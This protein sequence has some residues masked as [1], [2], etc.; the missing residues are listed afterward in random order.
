M[1]HPVHAKVLRKRR[2]AA[3]VVVLLVFLGIQ[4]F[5]AL[6]SD[7]LPAQT[8]V[9]SE[10]SGTSERALSVLERLEVKG[11]APKSG[12]KRS[13]F[14]D[15]WAS[16]AG[17]DMRNRMLARAMKEETI[18]DDGCVVLSGVLDDLYTAKT[19]QFV[20]GSSTSS[21]VQIDHVV[22]LSDAWQK[23]AQNLSYENRVTFANDPLNLL[24]VDGK[25][26]QDKGDSDAASWLPP[27]KEY[28]CQ[29]VARQVAVKAK[30]SLWVT[31]AEQSAIRRVLNSC[32]EQV[33]PIEKGDEQVS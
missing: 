17:C 30:Y 32:P 9:L 5:A 33:V 25:T 31:D 7:S 15:G 21:D 2:S 10:V 23:G 18:A 27:N 8:G 20:R 12:Y 19:I 3:V 13:E 16:I 11:R 24:A 22:A 6:N 1:I 4:L 26:N 29:Y 14:G 28:R